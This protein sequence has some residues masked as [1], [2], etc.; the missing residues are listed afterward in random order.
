MNNHLD[1]RETDVNQAQQHTEPARPPA[2]YNERGVIAESYYDLQGLA[3]LEAMREANPLPKASDASMLRAIFQSVEIILLNLSDVMRRSIADLGQAKLGSAMVKMSWAHG[4]HRVLVRLSMMPH[5]LGL[6]RGHTGEKGSLRLKDSPAF[7]EYVDALL[8]FDKC[9]LESVE[10]GLLP[11][12]KALAEESL[13]SVAFK[14]IHLAR[15]CNHESTVWERNLRE[16]R[17]PGRVESY[18][19]FVVSGEMRHAVYERELKGDTYFTQFRGLHQVPETLGEEVND[20]LEQAI[21]DMRD[22]R[23][24]SAADRLRAVNILTEGM[25]AS[26]PPMADNLATSDYHQIRE[27]LGLTSGSHSVC[28][29]FHMFTHLYEQLCD[30]LSALLLKQANGS[31]DGS[32]EEA[33]RSVEG[34]RHESDEAWLAHLL[35]GYGLQL[36]TFIFEWREEHLHM[37]RNNL[38]GES[39]K[40]LTGSPDAVKAVKSMRD[41]AV[42]KDPMM[43]L[44]RAC[45]LA[46]DRSEATLGELTAYLESEGSLD[47]KIL[48]ATGRATQERFHDVQERLGFFANRCTF[49]APP[50]RTV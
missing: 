44:A 3:V 30:E 29:R 35:I 7:R 23:L 21:R 18:E 15:V 34:K 36:R 22:G 41:S 31:T 43:R 13:D 40:S 28:L 11:M 50:R 27:N 14:L 38:G 5:Q 16:I 45:E 39:T 47:S 48:V 37:P 24:S 46:S 19:Q 32:V 8:E 6:M 9:V 25:L 42:M 12:Q 4:F 33:I 26:I 17:V 20:N 49:K 1:A 2:V 10:S